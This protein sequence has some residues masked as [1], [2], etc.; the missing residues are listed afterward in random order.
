MRKLNKEEIREVLRPLYKDEESFEF[1]MMI[2]QV[3]HEIIMQKM[4]DLSLLEEIKETLLNVGALNKHEYKGSEEALQ[5]LHDVL[6]E[7]YDLYLKLIVGCD[8]GEQD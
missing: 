2:D 5:T 7:C 1:G 3:E 4:L 6:F 8:K